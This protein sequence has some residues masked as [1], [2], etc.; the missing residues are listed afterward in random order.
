MGRATTLQSEVRLPVGHKLVIDADP[1]IGDALALLL[2][3][4]D[5]EIEVIGL[6]AT[7][8][9]V[10]G[11]VA[12]RNIQAIIDCVDPPRRPRVGHSNA[13]SPPFPSPAGLDGPSG[14]GEWDVPVVGLHQRH[15]SAKLLVEIVRDRPREITLLTLGPLTNVGL[16][17]EMAPDFLGLLGG[18]VCLGGTV[19]AGGDVSAVAEFNVMAS[20]E[21]AR[22]VLTSPVAKTLVPLDVSR[23]LILS[24]DQYRRLAQRLSG[25]IG[26]LVESIV[27]YWFRT[28]HE[29]LG[30]EGVVLHAVAAL[31]AVTQ[32]QLFARRAMRVDVELSGQLTRGM[33]V[34]DRRR[35]ML[36]ESNVD[37]CVDVEVQGVLDYMIRLLADVAPIR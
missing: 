17:S 15:E 3:L 35:K 7:A 6:T 20:V 4:V 16:A 32:P 9:R 8:G 25:P 5:P 28:H 34:M 14:L 21:T 12:T 36:P 29:Q 10:S 13:L 2:A 27:P 26:E 24:P 37:A 22:R 30:I 11:L 31:A 33:T 19:G 18:L 1:G 23:R